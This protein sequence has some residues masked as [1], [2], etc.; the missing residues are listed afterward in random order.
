MC[1]SNPQQGI[2]STHVTTTHVTQGRAEYE[3]TIPRGTDEG[4]DLWEAGKH[5]DSW[6]ECA[7]LWI[8]SA[9]DHI[10]YGYEGKSMYGFVL[11]FVKDMLDCIIYLTSLK[12]PELLEMSLWS[13]TEVRNTWLG[14]IALFSWYCS[15]TANCKQRLATLSVYFFQKQQEITEFFF[16]C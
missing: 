2:P 7:K 6:N 3:S 13:P 5:M 16:C 12:W 14:H 1:H 4:L 9:S 8:W 11:I 15:G 10:C